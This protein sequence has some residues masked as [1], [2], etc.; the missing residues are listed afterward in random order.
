MS[1]NWKYRRGSMKLNERGDGCMGWCTRRHSHIRCVPV[2]LITVYSG[3]SR[4]ADFSAWQGVRQWYGFS[5]GAIPPVLLS[6]QG[7]QVFG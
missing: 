2:W 4:S 7:C 3:L 6:G 5:T 1:G